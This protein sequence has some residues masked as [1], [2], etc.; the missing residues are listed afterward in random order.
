MKRVALYFGSFN[1]VHSG[2]IALAEWVIEQGLCDEVVLIVSPHNPIKDYAHLAPE[3]HRYEMCCLAC[4]ES[5][6]PDKILVSAVE[7]TLPKPSYTINTLRYLKQNFGE[8]MQFAVLIGADNMEIFDRWVSH[9][10]IL[11]DYEVMVYPRNGY[12]AGK[13]AD[14]VRYLADAPLFD[15]A[16]TEIRQAVARGESIE[17]KVCPSVA[18]Y[19]GE[20]G[21]WR[22]ATHIASLNER[23]ATAEEADASLLVER[24]M[25]HYRAG[26]YA[27]AL[28]DFR[29]AVAADAENSEAKE[30]LKIT[31]EK[32]QDNR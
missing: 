4:A 28:A 17:G 14:K 8:Q 12:D 20:Q 29:E 25:W 19:I 32:L 10:E 15:I 26:E 1:P 27:L 5:K 30:F 11:R 16:A 6:Y 18:K 3:F 7:F 9:D 31:E 2:H 21:L 13:Y 23:I 22:P 24:G